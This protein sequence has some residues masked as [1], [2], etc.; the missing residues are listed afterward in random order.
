VLHLVGQ[1]LVYISDARNHKHKIGPEMSLPIGV[2]IL[3]FIR[4][5]LRLE[6]ILPKKDVFYET[7]SFFKQ[8]A[9]ETILKPPV[10]G[11]NPGTGFLEM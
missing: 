4:F 11:L 1:L 8:Q 2:K 3:S 6:M 5:I 9:M 10:Q 7:Q